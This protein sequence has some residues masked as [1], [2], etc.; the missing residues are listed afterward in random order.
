[1]IQTQENG[2][3]PHSGPNFGPLDPDSGRYIFFIN[4]ASSGTRYH[5]QLSSCT[6]SEKTNDPILRKLCDGQTERTLFD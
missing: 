5:G 3:K 4:L 1:M 2:E 6:M